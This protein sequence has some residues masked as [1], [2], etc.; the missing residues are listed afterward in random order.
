MLRFPGGAA[1][2][3]LV[4]GQSDFS[5]SAAGASLA[6]L[7]SPC[8]VSVDGARVFVADR[9]NARV[10]F[11]DAPAANG[12]AGTAVGGVSLVAPEAVWAGQAGAAGHLLLVADGG[13]GAV[14]V[15]DGGTLASKFT[16]TGLAEPAGVFA[17]GGMLFVAERG[18]NRVAVRDPF[19]VA[20]APP[21]FVLGQPALSS[22]LPNTGGVSPASLFLGAGPAGSRAASGIAGADMGGSVRLFVADPGNARVLRFGVAP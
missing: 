5:G 7:S 22:T 11:W 9:G 3:D 6:A 18:R 12:A 10:L 13:A 17:A 8:G 20:D 15:L 1:A 2:A 19:P 4:L 16:V 21:T 14:L